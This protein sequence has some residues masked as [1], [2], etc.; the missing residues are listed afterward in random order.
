VD[1]RLLRNKIKQITARIDQIRKQREQ[2]RRARKKATVPTIALVGYTNAGKSTLFNRLTGALVYVADRLFATLDP[3]LRRVDLP[4]IGEVILADT[5][6][7]IRHLPH[8]LVEAFHATL[9]EVSEA[10][11]LL[12]VIDASDPNRQA[13]IE[14]VNAVL[15]QID[16]ED[17]PQLLVLNKIDLC[18]NLSVGLERDDEKQIRRAFISAQESQGID[19]LKS[20]MTERLEKDIIQ[21][22]LVLTPSDAKLRAHFY[23]TKALQS[24]TID[25]EGNYHVIVRMPKI[26]WQKLKKT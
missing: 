15:S 21:R 17:V 7:F 24:E 1:R 10:D 3:T 2:G 6:G 12:H 4:E 13:N 11:L 5:V 18:E 8:D 14:Q 19:L 22:E 23:Q 20:A 9:E 26:E 25:A 16:A